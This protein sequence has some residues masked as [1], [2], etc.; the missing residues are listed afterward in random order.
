MCIASRIYVMILHHNCYLSKSK[1]EHKICADSVYK[2][3]IA[4]A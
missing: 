3:V 2:I 4:F 1:I